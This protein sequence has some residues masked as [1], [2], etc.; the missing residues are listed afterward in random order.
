MEFNKK[1]KV[2]GSKWVSPK[3][4]TTTYQFIVPEH[5]TFISSSSAL[6]FDALGITGKFM[7]QTKSLLTNGKYQTKLKPSPKKIALYCEELDSLHNEIDSQPSTQLFSLDVKNNA[8]HFTS[9][10][11]YLP[12]SSSSPH[13]SLHLTLSDENHLKCDA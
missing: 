8:V 9:P 3:I 1:I 4:D 7:T 2:T 11:I 10:P 5:H 12:L 6:L 13:N